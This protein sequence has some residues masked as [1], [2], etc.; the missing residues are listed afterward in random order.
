MA[1]DCAISP[2]KWMQSVGFDER[3]SIGPIGTVLHPGH[4]SE[5]CRET[6]DALG[7]ETN[8]PRQ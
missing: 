7:R 2:C 8:K 5:P 4:Y 1:P 6:G 3:G